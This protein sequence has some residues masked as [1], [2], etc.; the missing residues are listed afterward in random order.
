LWK[1]GTRVVEAVVKRIEFV[2]QPDPAWDQEI[3]FLQARAV[4]PIVR[5]SEVRQH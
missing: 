4:F 2:Y 1:N 5:C 3:R